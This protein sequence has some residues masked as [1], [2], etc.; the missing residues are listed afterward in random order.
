VSQALG[1]AGRRRTTPSSRRSCNRLDTDSRRCIPLA[2]DAE[3]VGNGRAWLRAVQLDV[4]G[5][6][7]LGE[8]SSRSPSWCSAT[9]SWGPSAAQEVPDDTNILNSQAQFFSVISPVLVYLYQLAIWAAF[10]GSLQALSTIY[11]YTAREAFAPSFRALRKDENFQTLKIW[12]NVY[13][14]GGALFL[15]FTGVSYTTVISFAGVLGGVL[16]LGIWGFAQL[17]TE[18]KVLPAPF[19]MRRWVQVVVLLS[20]LFLT[21]AGLLALVQFFA[22]LL[23]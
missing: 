5:L 20:S 19:R 1:P 23:G 12:V 13:T 6:L 9:W 11:P 10:F 15:L 3:N 8:R 17:W 4:R 21:A 2:A 14:F 16:S 7:R 22:D 18:H